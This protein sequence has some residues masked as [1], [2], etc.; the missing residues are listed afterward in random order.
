MILKKR[1]YFFVAAII[2][3][4][5][6]LFLSFLV[7]KEVLVNLDFDTT[8]KLQ[9]KIPRRWDYHLSFFS[10]IATFEMSLLYLLIIFAF[11]ALKYKRLFVAIFSFFI[12]LFIE[13]MGKLFIFHP[14]PPYMFFRYAFGFS[15]PS[16]YIHTNYSYPSGHMSRTVFFIIIILFLVHKYVKNSTLRFLIAFIFLSLGISMFISRIYL[17]EHWFSDVSGG[18]LLGASI[19]IFSLAF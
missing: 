10:L 3:S 15:F 8:V 7:S 12:I 11:I 14:G 2:L 9:D 4:A 16:S 5:T 19:A 13:L 1:L 17:G 18:V 6:F